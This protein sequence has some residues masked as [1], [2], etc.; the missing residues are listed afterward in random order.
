MYIA[1]IPK[2]IDFS[3]FRNVFKGCLHAL[4]DSYLNDCKI[5]YEVVSIPARGHYKQRV[6]ND[7]R[8]DNLC[9]R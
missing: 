4:S 7:H 3:N 6:T 2:P 5:R 1:P 9:V 8:V